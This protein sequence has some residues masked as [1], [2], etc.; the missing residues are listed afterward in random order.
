M[1]LPSLVLNFFLWRVSRLLVFCV[2][3]LLYCW[4]EEFTHGVVLQS[5]ATRH[6]A[7]FRLDLKLFLCWSNKSQI[8]TKIFSLIASEGGLAVSAELGL[9]KPYLALSAFLTCLQIQ[10]PCFFI[11][12]FCSRSMHSD[13]RCHHVTYSLLAIASP[14]QL[15]S[16]HH[17]IFLFFLFYYFFFL[18]S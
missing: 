17:M 8:M 16:Y 3:I 18:P 11:D 12:T 6:I 9:G 7:E 5:R 10:K 14:I 1:F 4:L 2:W 15:L 13:D